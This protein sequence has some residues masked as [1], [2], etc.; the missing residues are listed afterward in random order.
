MIAVIGSGGM[1]GCDVC[2]ILRQQSKPFTPLEI[3][4]MDITDRQSVAATLSRIGPTVII[5]CAAYTN[6]DMA[7]EEKDLAFKVNHNGPKNLSEYAAAN[8]IPLCHISTDYVFDGKKSEP[9]CENEKT[10]PIGVYGASKLAGENE[11]RNIQKHFV[12]RTAWLYGKNGK[13]FVTTIL[14][15]ASKHDELK[16]VSDQFGSPTYTLDLAW[17]IIEI[18]EKLPF[19][20]YH[21]TNS[22]KAS[23]FELAKEALKIRGMGTKIIPIS[24]N[25]YPAKA[26]RPAYSVLSNIKARNAGLS[27][28]P[29]WQDA[30][31]RFLK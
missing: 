29:R 13:N 26:A 22:G 20:V 3:S 28:M 31:K 5:N 10:E 30:L 27:Q 12:I 19:G 9:I 7:E 24:S 21:V 11:V 6:V 23:W 8:D 16:V 14:E 18:V 1:L 15:A 2:N 4:E 25:E 17:R